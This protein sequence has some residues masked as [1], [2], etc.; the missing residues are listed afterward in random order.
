MNPILTFALI[1]LIF[2]PVGIGIMYTLY[3]NTV[4]FSIATLIFLA[5]LGVAFLGFLIGKI[6]ISATYWAL[7]AII[8]WL[9]GSNY[10]VTM[11][12]QKP[13]KGLKRNIDE[14]AEGNLKTS[15]TNETTGRNDEMGEMAKSIEKLID[16][17]YQITS[18]IQESSG[19][20][21]MLSERINQGASQLSQGAADQAASAE[22]VSSSMEEMVAN[23][24]QNTDNSKQTEIIAVESAAGIKKGN[25]SVVT[26]ADSMKM[27]A[28]KISI[29]G[30][31]AFQTNILALNAAVEA[32]RAG[33]HGRGF[34]V[35]AAEVRKLAENSKVAADQIN[36]L[37]GKGVSISETAARDLSL[38]APEIEKTAKLVQEI[39]AASIEQNSGAEQINNAMQRLNQIIQQN[40]ASSDQLAQSS[41]ELAKESETLKEVTNFFKF[42]DKSKATKKTKSKTEQTT[43]PTPPKKPT[44]T[45]D[46]KRVE[47]IK[48]GLETLI[49]PKIE[50]EKGND[51]TSNGKTEGLVS[52]TP[53]EKA[54]N[55]N[56]S[57]D[58][59]KQ[60]F[61]R[62]QSQSKKPANG[63]NIKMFDED[64][65]DSEYE[66]F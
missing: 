53:E 51:K 47:K 5:S 22:E 1:L 64:S 7:P 26:A 41:D 4:V 33:E 55:A 59:T 28:E 52:F 42:E 9:L 45:T 24:Q 61:R 31:I 56:G 62:E 21:I 13:L 34:A 20:L 25:D 58:S 43:S 23:I 32:A 29:I 18:K 50:T 2:I 16:Q 60:T 19:N 44:I 54:D 39:T 57:D 63:F 27:I 35:V 48:T 10:F 36:E 49:K 14:L 46:T 15:V 8:V 37:S 66:R 30:D 11:L 65:K 3:R 38:I 6:D 40:A 17:L 12:I